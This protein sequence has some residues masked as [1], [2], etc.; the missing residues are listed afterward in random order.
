MVDRIER[1]LRLLLPMSRILIFSDLHG[2]TKALDRLLAID[3]DYYVAAGDLT[4]FA[5]G[6][7]KMGALLQTK[8]DRMYVMPGNH[9][10]AADI[11]RFCGAFGLQNFH[12]RT[13]TVGRY[14]V[15]GLGY[16]NITPFQTPGE[17]TEEQLAGLLAPRESL[18]PLVLIC[19][20]PPKDTPLDQAGPGKHFGS[21]SIR[22]F[23][24][25]L[26]AGVLLLRPYS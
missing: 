22:S 12:H 25:S 5:R 16:S 19:H 15:A 20:C 8:A 10:S 2:D 26:P 17:Y 21:P 9:E 3:A 11:E 1:T 13:L 24:D 6:L 18:Q 4:N 7:D 23:I 14:H